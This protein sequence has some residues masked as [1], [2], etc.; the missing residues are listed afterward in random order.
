[1]ERR[2]HMI[3]ALGCRGRSL[4][5]GGIGDGMTL[6]VAKAGVMVEDRT[7]SSGIRVL[8]GSV[9]YNSIPD[10]SVYNGRRLCCIEGVLILLVSFPP[11]LTIDD[12]IFADYS[13]LSL[14]KLENSLE[15]AEMCCGKFLHILPI[16]VRELFARGMQRCDSKFIYR[17]YIQCLTQTP[18]KD[19]LQ[20]LSTKYFEHIQ[21][22]TLR[23]RWK[24]NYDQ[25]QRSVCFS[26]TS[27]KLL[28]RY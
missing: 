3:R 21:R 22:E 17:F 20:G 10:E 14:C 25:A 6:L 1:M 2:L 9:L 13:A 11:E 18:I 8:N 23:E 12:G 24:C 26:P 19:H 4:R 28:T 27:T 7:L 5:W 16:Y 15:M